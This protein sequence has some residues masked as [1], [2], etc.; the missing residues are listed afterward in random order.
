MPRPAGRSPRTLPDWSSGFNLVGFSS[1]ETAVPCRD[2]AY[3]RAQHWSAATMR[4]GGWSADGE[5]GV[6]GVL[7]DAGSGADRSCPTL[8]EPLLAGCVNGPDVG[9]AVAGGVGGAH[10]L[11]E[12]CPSPAGGGVGVVL[13]SVGVDGGGDGLQIHSTVGAGLALS[14]Q[15]AAAGVGI[16][17]EE[18]VGDLVSRDVADTD[19]VSRRPDDAGQLLV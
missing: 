17:A 3:G 1:G 4:L 15:D 11:R 19:E 16:V 2:V 18:E 10:D 12:G 7:V 8:V 6:P 9:D 14:Q 13:S 5:E